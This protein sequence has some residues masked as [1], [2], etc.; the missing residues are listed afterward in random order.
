MKSFS[1]GIALSV[2]LVLF[3]LR[4][5]KWYPLSELHIHTEQEREL[6]LWNQ[7]PGSV[8]CGWRTNTT[9]VE[10][11]GRQSSLILSYMGISHVY[12][13]EQASLRR[14]LNF[15]C[16]KGHSKTFP[17]QVNTSS[18]VQIFISY[19]KETS[20][21]YLAYS[22]LL[23]QNPFRQIIGKVGGKLWAWAQFHLREHL[24]ASDLECYAWA[25]SEGRK[26][27]EIYSNTQWSVKIYTVYMYSL[28]IFLQFILNLWKCQA[29]WDLCGCHLLHRDQRYPQSV[30]V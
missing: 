10:E 16:P 1:E 21:K 12:L 8:L 24:A 4:V 26:I 19:W 23:V 27:V 7:W 9:E 17:H 22:C 28:Y 6:C 5:E 3:P 15:Q 11:R 20:A 25:A 29:C 14:K 30:L 13:L 18:P 2:F